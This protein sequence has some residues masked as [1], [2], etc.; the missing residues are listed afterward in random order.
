MRLFRPDGLA[1]VVEEARRR[2]QEVQAALQDGGLFQAVG[3]VP[4]ERQDGVE[5]DLVGDLGLFRP[6]QAFQQ[7]CAALLGEGQDPAGAALAPSSVCWSSVPAATS[8]LIAG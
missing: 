4:Q 3:Q 5:A 6:P 2:L 7:V 1:V 8:R